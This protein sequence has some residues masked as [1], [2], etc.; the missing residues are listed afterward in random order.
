MEEVEE[1]KNLGVYYG[2]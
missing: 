1:I 2:M